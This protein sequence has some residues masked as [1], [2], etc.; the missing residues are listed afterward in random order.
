MKK[1]FCALLT[2]F[3][4]FTIFPHNSVFS[5]PT[6]QEQIDE[7]ERKKQEKESAVEDYKKTVEDCKQKSSEFS[8]KQEDLTEELND[9][10]IKINKAQLKTEELKNQEDELRFSYLTT[11][12]QIETLEESI[13][14]KEEKLD[15]LINALY[16]DYCKRYVNYLFSSKNINEI[17]DKGVY[18][19]YL[20]QADADFFSELKK[21][22]ELQADR[23]S[24]LVVDQLKL[25]DVKKKQN[26]VE[27]DLNKLRK[28]KDS[29]I[30]NITY[31]AQI[32]KR[33]METAVSALSLAEAEIRRIA[34][35]EVDLERLKELQNKEMGTLIWPIDG[36]VTSGF[37]MRMHPIFGV[38]RMH[39]GI[40][41]DQN[42]GYPIKAVAEGI[43]T[44]SGWLTGYGNCVMIMHDKEHT[45]LYAH[46]KTRYVKKG[47]KVQQGKVIG[48]VGSTGWSTG[49]HL[50]FEIR[51]N[52]D[53]VN[54][55]DYLP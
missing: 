34:S 27:A 7:L 11:E 50:H 3:L 32:N 16:K 31:S 53:Y 39:T 6:L 13:I 28:Q 48:E 35:K 17:M 5:E 22:R 45:S 8:I 15:V 51:V 12:K 25:L 37:G 26:E 9:L 47:E 33:M 1:I 10:G 46:M 30:H 24:S 19:K 4:F 38:Y 23:K 40:D 49:P 55:R 14:R 43:V 2:I 42:Y 36:P 54:P 41:I 29:E 52:G 44:Y 21:D 20:Y 18:L